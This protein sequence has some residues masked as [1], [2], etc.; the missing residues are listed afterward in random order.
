MKIWTMLH[1][2]LLPSKL[3]KGQIFKSRYF[4]TL[5][6]MVTYFSDSRWSI[7]LCLVELWKFP[8]DLMLLYRISREKFE[9]GFEPRTSWF[10]FKFFLLRSYNVNFPR[11]K[12]WVCFQLIIWFECY[13][14][15]LFLIGYHLPDC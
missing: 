11:H 4:S 2:D 5:F 12:L 10:W 1:T 8:C 13:F 15:Q 6:L 3:D 14:L 7:Y 9:P